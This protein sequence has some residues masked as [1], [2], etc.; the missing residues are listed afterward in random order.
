MASS[1]ELTPPPN[2]GRLNSLPFSDIFVMLI[3]WR[4]SIAVSSVLLV[5]A[6][7]PLMVTPARLVPR[8]VYTGMVFLPPRPWTIE[9]RFTSAA[10]LAHY[11]FA[12]TF[13]LPGRDG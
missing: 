7:S 5:A 2:V 8:Y 10:R 6:S 9:S 11:R 1:L 12:A 4:R 13:L 3:C